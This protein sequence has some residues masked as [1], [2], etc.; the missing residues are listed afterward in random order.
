MKKLTKMA[1]LGSALATSVW[2]APV[3]LTASDGVT[4]HPVLF[5]HG[6][7]SEM[8]GAWGAGG[9]GSS[10]V[11]ECEEALKSG[12][13]SISAKNYEVNLDERRVEASILSFDLEIIPN[14][15]LRPKLNL[16]GFR[17]LCDLK[18]MNITFEA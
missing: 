6:I 5:V 14:C 17:E 12:G 10:E 8:Q 18:G 13:Y 15:A 2:S 11:S 7:N 16:W 9:A 4:N 3:A 1:L